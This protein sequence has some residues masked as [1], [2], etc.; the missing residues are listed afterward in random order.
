MA[1]VLAGTYLNGFE[2][3]I[4]RSRLEDEGVMSFVMDADMSSLGL[5]AIVP[6]RLM[7]DDEDL[8]AALKILEA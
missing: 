6:I 4:A 1:L 2:A 5:G 3:A 7:V 8:D